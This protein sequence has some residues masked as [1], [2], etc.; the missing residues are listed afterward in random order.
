MIGMWVMAFLFLGFPSAWDKVFALVSGFIVIVVAFKLERR[1]KAASGQ[2]P[3]V[4][5][6]NNSS[7]PAASRDVRMND[8]KPSITNTDISMTS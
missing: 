2:V 3:F 5:Y 6:K 4:D 1:A 8:T 7:Q